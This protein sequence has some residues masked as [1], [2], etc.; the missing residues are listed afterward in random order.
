MSDRNPWQFDLAIAASHAG[1]IDIPSG[2]WDWPREARITWGTEAGQELATRRHDPGLAPFFGQYD[3]LVA[4]DP[5]EPPGKIELPPLAREMTLADVTICVTSFLRMDYLRRFIVSVREHYPTLPII[6]ADNSPAEVQSIPDAEWV[7][8]Q[9][10]VRFLALPY[11][12]GLPACRNAAVVAAE[13]PLVMIAEEDFVFTRETRLEAMLDVLNDFRPHVVGGLARWNDG[14]ANHWSYRIRIHHQ[15]AAMSDLRTP[16]YFTPRGVRFR[17]TESCLNFFLA[18]RDVLVAVPWDEQFTIGHEH[19][20]QTL[21]W[22]ATGVKVVYTTAAIIGHNK[23]APQGSYKTHRERSTKGKLRTK[24]GLA[25]HLALGGRP[26]P[27]TGALPDAHLDP[28]LPAVS[29]LPPERFAEIF[30]PLRGRMVGIVDAGGNAGDRIIH[31][32]ARQLCDAFGVPW[33]TFDPHR[34]RPGD[35]EQL[36]LF[37]GGNM[38]TPYEDGR[39]ARS[40][41]LATGLPC[42]LLPQ[43]WMGP[44]PAD[45]Y[46]RVF[47]RERDSQ[48]FCQRAVLAPDL[49]LGW[50]FNR[51]APS[52]PRAPAKLFLRHDAES[53]FPEQSSW[54]GDPVRKASTP[55]GY[56]ALAAGHEH[57]I[58]DRLHFAIVGL[59]AGCRVTL[60]PG[61]YHKNRAMWE[62]WL[63]DLGAEWADCPPD[64]SKLAAA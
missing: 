21:T 7:K 43:S 38:G 45:R 56:L 6:V 32:A 3:G 19:F 49:A 18:R 48:A 30:E 51:P 46:Y 22:K 13:T 60:L 28:Q 31:S 53:L 39:R 10:G 20:D 62:T 59:M 52:E 16:W 40:A 44:E 29:L 50:R 36:L 14:P 1:L 61:S 15:V 9:P 4:P 54:Q 23:D 63:A 5:V 35:L 41:A 57:V 27:G 58:T 64:A 17:E 8:A 42:V 34:D 26:E 55:R 24:W 25:D 11:D 2:F 47:A 33:R 12:A 37:G